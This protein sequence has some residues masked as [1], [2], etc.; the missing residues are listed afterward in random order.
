MN[1]RPWT[2]ADLARLRELYPSRPVSD[3]AREL[4][5]SERSV[6]NTANALGLRKFRRTAVDDRFLAAISRM[7]RR[8][9]SDPEIA[10][11]L[12]CDRHTVSRHRQALGLPS[13]GRNE[14]WRRKI[15]EGSI[16]QCERA[17]VANLGELRS[18]TFRCTSRATRD[19]QTT[20][21]TSH[22]E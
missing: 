14:R 22:A 6:Y 16:R 19:S 21:M 3:C 1:G 13:R 10:T 20:G 7:N 8:G 5:R 9:L 15:R 12:G 18:L 4:G 11:A 17:G 2:D